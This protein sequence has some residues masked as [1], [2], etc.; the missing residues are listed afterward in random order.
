MRGSADTRRMQCVMQIGAMDHRIRIAKP[1]TK[2]AANRD[3]CDLAAVDRIHHDQL[4]DEY[5]AVAHRLPNTQRVERGK[6]IRAELQAGTDF[7]EVGALLE[8][9]NRE[10][11]A[12]K[13]QR[14]RQ[15]TDAGADHQHM[16][17][18]WHRR[19][20]R[21]SFVLRRHRADATALLLRTHQWCGQPR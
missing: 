13:S 5:C 8:Q 1:L 2:G 6:R 10:I 4:V 9:I 7:T 16:G 17:A 15:A 18:A 3:C 14:R 20:Q 21:A 19:V 12:C 11:A